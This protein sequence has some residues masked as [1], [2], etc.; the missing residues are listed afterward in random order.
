MGLLEQAWLRQDTPIKD[1]PHFLDVAAEHLRRAD[2][3]SYIRMA[4]CRVVILR[5][6]QPEWAYAFDLP[7]SESERPTWRSGFTLQFLSSPFS[8]G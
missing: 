4:L 7:N 2:P 1:P 6:L 3:C 8:Y 5:T